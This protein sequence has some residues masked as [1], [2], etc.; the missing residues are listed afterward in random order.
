MLNCPCRIACDSSIMGLVNRADRVALRRRRV[1]DL[2]Y[3]PTLE[4]EF[5][6][7]YEQLNKDNLKKMR[8]RVT[9]QRN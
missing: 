2:E 9:A 3:P 1:C 6:R 4:S 5:Q 7:I 8:R